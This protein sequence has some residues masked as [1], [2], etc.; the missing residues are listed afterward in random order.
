MGCCWKANT[1]FL[2]NRG[3]TYVAERVEVLGGGQWGKE[4]MHM[5]V[6]LGWWVQGG[7][8]HGGW[9]WMVG[10]CVVQ[11]LREPGCDANR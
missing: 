5:G 4:G 3:N 6:G 8:A 1:I 10:A 2:A 11:G 7:N 9:V